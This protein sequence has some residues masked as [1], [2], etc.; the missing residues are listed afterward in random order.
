M[1]IIYALIAKSSD[2]ALCECTEY[3]GNFQQITRL[4]LRKIKKNAKYTYEYD[5]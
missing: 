3:A 1:S 2:V 5:K 4:L